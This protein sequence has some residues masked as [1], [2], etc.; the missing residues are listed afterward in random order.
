MRLRSRTGRGAGAALGAVLALTLAGCSTGGGNSGSAAGT[1]PSSPPRS[2]APP[3]RTPDSAAPAPPPGAPRSIAALGDSIT[4]AFDACGALADCPAASWA[5]GTDQGVR[6]LAARLRTPADRTWN[7]ARTGA[8]MA[9]LDAQTEQALARRPE[10]VTIMMG[11][12]DACRATPEA[13]TPVDAYRRDF[14]AALAKLERG[15]PAARVYVSSVP[16]LER[17]WEVGRGSENARQIWGLG[18]CP[19]ML[20]APDSQA[21]EAVDRRAR[22]TERVRAYNEVLRTQCA[23]HPRCRY[24]DG[25]AFAFDFTSAHLSSWDYFHPSEKGQASLAAL[26]YERLGGGG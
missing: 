25:A 26:A 24:D 1:S 15:A 6:S 14:A 3:P 16:N 12:N 17:L 23:K 20:R 21:A 13:M 5:T 9:D 4:R 11:A 2:A 10:L 7:F 22:V 18:I 19:S 8:R